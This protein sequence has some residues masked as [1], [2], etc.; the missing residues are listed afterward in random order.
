[1]AALLFTAGFGALFLNGNFD[2]LRLATPELIGHALRLE[3]VTLLVSPWLE[4]SVLFA[5]YELSQHVE[6][7][8]FET[9]TCRV[10]FMSLVYSSSAQARYN[11]D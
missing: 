11:L 2:V 3:R 1:M 8:M 10:L 5:K 7:S 9:S 4:F 6:N